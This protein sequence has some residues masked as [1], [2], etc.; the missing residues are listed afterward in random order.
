MQTEENNLDDS[1]DKNETDEKIQV[2]DENTPAAT[3]DQNNVEG[4]F[5]DESKAENEPKTV[6][7]S[8]RT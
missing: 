3:P 2:E 7:K 8:S 1:G 4:D 6:V 5:F